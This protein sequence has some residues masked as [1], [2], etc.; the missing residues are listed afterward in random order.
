MRENTTLAC[1]LPPEL[2]LFKSLDLKSR[3]LPLQIVGIN[4]DDEG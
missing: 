2:L 4:P 3:H 1:T